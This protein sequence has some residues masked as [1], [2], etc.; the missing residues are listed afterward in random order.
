MGAAPG[1]G[2]DG[3]PPDADFGHIHGSLG[4]D[5]ETV[6]SAVIVAIDG[7][8]GWWSYPPSEAPTPKRRLHGIVHRSHAGDGHTRARPLVFD[9]KKVS[10]DELLRVFFESHDPTQLMRQG[11]ADTGPFSYAEEY[12]Q[13]Y[14]DANPMGYCG[15]GG[16]GVSCPVGAAR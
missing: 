16:T 2:T 7:T 11:I 13:Q 14:L 8:D 1:H 5:L 4:V 3:G 6:G 10:F 15:L 12:H 9:P